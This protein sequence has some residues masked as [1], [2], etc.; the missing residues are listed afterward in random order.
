MHYQ[1]CCPV[2]HS[3]LDQPAPENIQIKDKF[4]IPNGELQQCGNRSRNV[5]DHG[6]FAFVGGMNSKQG[7]IF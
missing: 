7:T 4:E 2:G 5:R 3:P 1:V 6:G